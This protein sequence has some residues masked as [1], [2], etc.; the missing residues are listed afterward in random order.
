MVFKTILLYMFFIQLKKIMCRT[1]Q[2]SRFVTVVK[3]GLSYFPVRRILFS[4]MS[5]R[6]VE[7]LAF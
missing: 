3:N 6:E 7:L 5:K 4:C 1:E 2:P